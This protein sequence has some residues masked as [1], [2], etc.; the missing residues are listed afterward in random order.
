MKERVKPCLILNKID[1]LILELRFSPTEAYQHICRII[2]QVNVIMSSM[3]TGD[4][5][6]KDQSGESWG[7]ENETNESLF[8]S[9]EKGNVVFASA[10]D[11]WAFGLGYFA[12]KFAQKLDLP[13]AKLRRCLWGEYYF[14]PKTKSVQK[15]PYSSSAVPMFVQMVLEPIWDVYQ[16]VHQ[17]NDGRLQQILR[18]LKLRKTLT[19]RELNHSNPTI[20]LQNIMRHW[21]PLSSAVL[22]MV[23]RTLPNPIEAQK[24]RIHQL[25]PP[26]TLSSCPTIFKSI[27]TCDSL[28]PVVVHVSKV[29]S[30]EKTLLSDG[31]LYSSSSTAEDDADEEILIAYCRVFSGELRKDMPLY[32]LSAMHNHDQPDASH[33]QA[34]PPGNIRP[35][36]IMGREMVAL[37]SVPAGNVVGIVGLG[38]SILKTATISSVLEC[39]SLTKMT[40]QAK[41]IVRVAIEP[42]D[43]RDFP[44]VERGLQLLNRADPAV[45]VFVQVN[46]KMKE[47]CERKKE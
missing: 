4:A 28:G 45:E 33:Y 5:L 29:T 17:S 20:V 24:V 19:D 31:H 11:G 41:P 14:N 6:M 10:V 36:M 26:S 38:D 18:S 46:E 15:K 44:I 34:I 47:E 43:P 35:Y 21:L 25:L 37:E 7:N 1:R 30:I 27:S 8:F 13:M 12:Q 22:R 9:P 2:E 16:A 32:V 42:K 40:Y 39:P 3:F 23:V